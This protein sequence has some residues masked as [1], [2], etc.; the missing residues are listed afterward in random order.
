MSGRSPS[1]W[2]DVFIADSRHVG[3]GTDT[4]YFAREAGFISI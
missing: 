4:I 2:R 1:G 3:V